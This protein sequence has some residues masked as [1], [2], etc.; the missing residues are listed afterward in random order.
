MLASSLKVGTLNLAG[1]N[2]SP[3]EYHDGGAEMESLSSIFQHR[4][5]LAS[6]P[7]EQLPKVAL[8]DK[9]FQRGRYCPL[10]NQRC[11]VV[12]GRLLDRA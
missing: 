1:I 8:V 3:F 12:R 11:G 7:K 9:K 4:F 5:G 6:I 10:Y 2:L